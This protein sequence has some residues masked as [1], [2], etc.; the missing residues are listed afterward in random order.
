MPKITINDRTVEV[1]AGTNVIEAGLKAGVQI[2]HYCYHPRLSV[3]GQCRMCLVEIS[4]NGKKMPKLQTAC[5]SYITKDGWSVRTDTPEVAEAQKGMMEFFLINHPLD[6]PICASCTSGV[7]VRTTIP[8]LTTL[9]EHAVWSLG[10]PSILTRHIR[11]WPTT[12]R[13]G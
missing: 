7:S 2:P 11:H 6:C 13:R 5:S 8:S 10:I 12:D 1:E 9:V 4:D 3:V